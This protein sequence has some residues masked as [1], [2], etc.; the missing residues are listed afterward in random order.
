MLRR[1]CL[2]VRNHFHGLIRQDQWKKYT[3][4]YLTYVALNDATFC[5]DMLDRHPFMGLL[6]GVKMI[7]DDEYDTQD[8]IVAIMTRAAVKSAWLAAFM[9]YPIVAPVVFGTMGVKSAWLLANDYGLIEKPLPKFQYAQEMGK[10]IRASTMIMQE[11][12]RQLNEEEE[13]KAQNNEK[14]Q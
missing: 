2:Y 13:V 12:V 11:I 1:Y 7:D 8:Y 9:C 6:L 10:R 14:Q 4:C 5:W 3:A